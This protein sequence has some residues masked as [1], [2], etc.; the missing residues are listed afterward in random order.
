MK[1]LQVATYWDELEFNDFLTEIP[2]DMVHDIRLTVNTNEDNA[3]Y[4]IL[5]TVI[6]RKEIEQCAK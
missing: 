4:P 2:A 3:D 6:Y 1:V 5:Y